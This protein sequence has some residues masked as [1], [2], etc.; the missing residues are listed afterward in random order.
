MGIPVR[1]DQAEVTRAESWLRNEGFNVGS[2]PTDRLF[3]TASGLGAQ[4]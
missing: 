1:A 4:R 2:V 3:V